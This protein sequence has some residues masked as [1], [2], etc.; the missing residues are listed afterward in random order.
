MKIVID[1]QALQTESRYRGIGRYSLALA[2][3]MITQGKAHE[4]LIALNHVFPDSV[5]VVRQKLGDILP[6]ENIVLFQIPISG[7]ALDSNN[8]WRYQTAELIREHFLLQ[9]RPDWV[10]ISTFFEGPETAPFGEPTAVTSVDRFAH[11]PTTITLYDFI[12]YRYPKHYLASPVAKFWYQ[13][14]LDNLQNAELLL[15][16]SEYTR[17]EAI[18]MLGLS[19]ER[20]VNISGD[21]DERFR[22]LNLGQETIRKLRA[23]YGLRSDFVICSGGI[24]YRKNIKRLIEAYA[25][26]PSEVR[27]HHQM[28]IVCKVEEEEL[29]RWLAMTSRLGLAKDEVV[30]SGYIS[31]EDLAALYNLCKLFVFPSL[32]EGFGLPVL[33]AMRCGAPVIASNSTSIPEIVGLEEALFDP[34]STESICEKLH[35]ALIDAHFRKRLCE[36]EQAEAGRFSWNASAKRALEAMEAVHKH[37]ENMRELKIAVSSGSPKPR[38][39]YVS[40]LP[41]EKSEIADYSAELLPDLA[42]YYEIDLITDLKDI[43]DAQLATKFRQRSIEAFQNSAHDY[44]R[45]LYHFGN[46]AFH[47]HMFALL[48]RYPGTAVLHDFFLGDILLHL[49][50]GRLGSIM[51]RKA[52][53]RS[54][55]YPA[56]QDCRLKGTEEIIS[57]YPCCLEVLQGA[58]GVI[59]HSDY[60]L[61]LAESFFTHRAQ[62][63]MVKIP[64]LCRLPTKPDRMTSRKTLGLPEKAFVVCS[65]GIPAFTKL[66]DRILNA[67]LSSHLAHEE[68]CYLVFVG[69]ADDNVYEQSLRVR[70]EAS[71]LNNRVIITGYV[72]YETYCDYLAAADVAVQ[73]RT[74]TRGE[75]SRSVLDCLAYGLATVVNNH[76]A[77][78]ELPENV[79]VKL[80][81]EFNDAELTHSLEQLYDNATLR[82]ALS[83][84]AINYVRTYLDPAHIARQYAEAI[85]SF[86][87]NHPVAIRE[88]LLSTIVALPVKKNLRERELV[89]VA[90]AIGE[91]ITPARERQLL[92]DISGLLHG[93]MKSGNQRAVRRIVE[94]LLMATPAGYRM[95][96]VYRSEGIYCYARRFMEGFLGVDKLG[97]DDI[98][99][100]AASGDIFLGL[101]LDV[102]IDK[103][104]KCWLQHHARR[105]LKVYFV[106]YDL[107]PLLMPECFPPDFRRLFKPWIESIAG[108]ADG[109]VCISRTVALELGQWLQ[110][111]PVTRLNPLRIGFFH[112]GSDIEE[113][114]PNSS[115]SPEEGTILSWLESCLSI[116]MVGI[117]WERK[118]HAQTLEAFEK[119][120]AEGEDI[121]LIIVG[122]Q[123]WINDNL[124]KRLRTHPEFGKRL[125][126]LDNASDELLLKLYNSASALL[127]ASESEG[128]GLPLVEA[129][130]HNLPIIARDL[131]VFREIAGDHAFYF[132]G[133]DGHSLAEAL[134]TWLSLYHRGKH[135]RS[136]GMSWLT[137]E[138][139]TEQLKQVLFE[140]RW[141]ASWEAER[142]FCWEEEDKSAER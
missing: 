138:E 127:M 38:L 82:E 31:D 85:E 75:T 33:E 76:G 7:T 57:T 122:K 13:R 21:A 61:K 67:W 29:R 116:L 111:Y 79:V 98:P 3:A 43:S 103:S 112:L 87:Q 92:L 50:I 84:T 9:L 107:L 100:E 8:S 121:L 11:L 80:S 119:L 70:I 24:D 6:P 105:G 25:R 12:P 140:S 53:Y 72:N 52:L 91:N 114:L 19:P 37:Q 78:A 117:L 41:P 51:F 108:L 60:A 139:S 68:H 32:Y 14:K 124:M 22:V 83:H 56:L 42:S 55:G 62:D 130:R 58:Q 97:L 39:A 73:L 86:A 134:K 136:E 59:V 45:V 54:H 137:W 28:V 17:R 15:A 132:N 109:L 110:Q 88:R 99:V 115:I 10:H 44:D 23:R 120:W 46:S 16:I 89:Q 142:G 104:S 40:P 90:H 47:S 96:P 113:N 64:S 30:F 27:D 106:V 102:N 65:F 69:E 36:H 128:F 131:P 4:F 20:V 26:L 94:K 48:A 125:I 35:Q 133:K 126:W 5:E 135:P 63:Y 49:E 141:M 123:G 101:H 2:R 1:L 74:R 81:D 129:A 71:G 95:E 18:E 77:F 66:L 34:T 118:G 93:E